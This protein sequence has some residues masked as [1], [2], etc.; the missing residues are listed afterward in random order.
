[1]T[2]FVIECSLFKELELFAEFGATIRS[3]LTR[4]LLKTEALQAG[5]DLAQKPFRDDERAAMSW[6]FHSG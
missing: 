1:M 5:A 6:H 2:L 4:L 3:S